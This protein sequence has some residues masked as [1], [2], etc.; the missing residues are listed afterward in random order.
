MKYACAPP[1]LPD[2]LHWFYWESYTTWL[3]GFA[4]FTVSYLWNASTY[5]I[6]KSLMDWSPGAAIA[7]A[8]AFLVVFWMLYDGICQRVRPAQ[9]RR[10]HRRRAGAGAGVRGVLAG[11]PLVCRA[12]PPSCWWA[13]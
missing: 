4:L 3:T 7:V 5:L 8:L 1:K 13:P 11:L 6:D 10:R 2:H 9:E 12:A